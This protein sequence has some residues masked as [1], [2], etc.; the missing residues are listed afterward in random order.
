MGNLMKINELFFED[1]E[2]V[3]YVNHLFDANDLD[4]Y[5]RG[6][7]NISISMRDE[8]LNGQ[9]VVKVN[10]GDLVDANKLRFALD[11]YFSS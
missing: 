5:M 8:T 4:D 11:E 1:D 9:E 2:A 10:F 6:F 7:H 3:M